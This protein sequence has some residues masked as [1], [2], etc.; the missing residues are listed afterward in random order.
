MVDACLSKVEELP[1]PPAAAEMS[2]PPAG[3]IVAKVFFL[4]DGVLEGVLD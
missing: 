2:L 1:G 3:A 4:C